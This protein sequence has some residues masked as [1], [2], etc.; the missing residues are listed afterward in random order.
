MVALP[1]LLV[2]VAA[3]VLTYWL[4]LRD[5]A[6]G[7]KNEVVGRLVKFVSPALSYDQSALIGEET[8]RSG[9]L[10]EHRIDSYRGEDC[11]SGNV[12]ETTV[13][14]SEVNAR[15]YSRGSKGEKHWHTLF[16]GL[17]FIADFN[18]HLR[19]RTVVV[20]DVAERV[21]GGWLGGLFQKINFSRSGELVKLESPEFER[22][23]AVYADDPVEA[24]YVLTPAMMERLVEFRER[25]DTGDEVFVSF[26]GPCVHVALP[27]DRDLFEPR[28]LGTVRDRRLLQEYFL[29]LALALGIV[30]DLDLNTRI[31]TKK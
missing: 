29:D 24:R 27:M 19:G 17:Y 3:V 1:L 21:L 9:R 12:G 7:F 20:P 31:W 13:R 18:K 6:W 10:F 4:S 23:Y 22:Y 5:Y 11:V 28:Y 16:K 30:E 8:F 2:G 26:A 14:F 15:Y 25:P